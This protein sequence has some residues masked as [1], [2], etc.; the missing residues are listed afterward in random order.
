MSSAEVL[1][2]Y[3]HKFFFGLAVHCTWV[4]CQ[5]LP[6]HPARPSRP[7]HG[8]AVQCT[9]ISVMYTEIPNLCTYEFKLPQIIV[10]LRKK[11]EKVVGFVRGECYGA[12][13]SYSMT[14]DTCSC[15]NKK[16][17]EKFRFL[18]V[19]RARYFW[20]GRLFGRKVS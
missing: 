2:P 14:L 20:P 8:L 1:V 6:D 3:V 13:N 7:P 11:I 5:T 10:L 4:C 16:V 12:K 15:K 9:W 17:F 19:H 18:V